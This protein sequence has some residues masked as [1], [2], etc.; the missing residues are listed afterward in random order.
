MR[1]ISYKP[2]KGFAFVPFNRRSDAEAAKAALDGFNIAGRNMAVRWARSDQYRNAS[3]DPDT[4]LLSFDGG[5]GVSSTT[6]SSGYGNNGNSSPSRDNNRKSHATSS[7]GIPRGVRPQFESSF[8]DDYGSK[9]GD[10]SYGSS[11]NDDEGSRGKRKYEG[12]Q[13]Q[14]EKKR[15]DANDGFETM[16]SYSG[17]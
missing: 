13:P 11:Y 17:R 4:G 16:T 14:A 7:H 10:R 3:V 8:A 1:R 12:D 6:S 5:S 15:L 9:N 2:E